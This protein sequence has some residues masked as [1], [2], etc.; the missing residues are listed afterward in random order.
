MSESSAPSKLTRRRFVAL[1]AATLISAPA[2][3]RAAAQ[4]RVAERV[5]SFVHTHTAETLSSVTYFR[6][7]NYVP[8]ALAKLNHLL[9]DFRTGSAHTVDPA[10]FDIL[11]DLKLLADRDAPYEI[12]SGYRSPATNEMLHNRSKGVATRSLHME[13]KAIDIRMTGF[14]CRKL[15]D[16][17]LGMRRGGVGYYGT[18]NF[19]HLDTGRVRSW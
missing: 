1:S 10:L 9:R 12:I 14:S 5:L 3:G 13:G 11:F 7:G 6:N 16:L 4:Q 15:R 8:A 19:I 18:S 17:A 2:V